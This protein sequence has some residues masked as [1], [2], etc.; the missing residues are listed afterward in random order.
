MVTSECVVCG[1]SVPADQP[2][3]SAQCVRRHASMVMQAKR[4]EKELDPNLAL[5]GVTPEEI[6]EIR[7]LFGEP[8]FGAS[9]VRAAA[10]INP[11]GISVVRTPGRPPAAPLIV[12]VVGV[13]GIILAIV[14][15]LVAVWWVT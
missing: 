15:L 7:R 1:A 3:C 9:R 5:S 6:D 12:R 14:G 4:A 13:I 2:F 10:R 11:D 8:G